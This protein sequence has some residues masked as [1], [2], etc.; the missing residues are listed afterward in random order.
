MFELDG[1]LHIP[2]YF[3]IISTTFHYIYITWYKKQTK[4][5]I[6]KLKN[7]NNNNIHINSRYFLR[8]ILTGHHD[9]TIDNNQ[10]L[11][12]NLNTKLFDQFTNIKIQYNKAL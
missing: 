10:L 3:N 11:F 8:D 1:R 2:F 5:I 12:L 7:D 9:N 4:F 6:I